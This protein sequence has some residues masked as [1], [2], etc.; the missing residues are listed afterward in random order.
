MKK[1]YVIV[2]SIITLSFFS[3]KIWMSNDN[4]FEE[5]EEEVKVANA[6]KVDVFVG[7]AQTQ[8]G[9]TTPNGVIK[10]TSSEPFKV[11]VPKEISYEIESQYGFKEWLAFSTSYFTTNDKSKNKDICFVDDESYKTVRRN[12]LNVNKETDTIDDSIVSFEKVYKTDDEGNTVLVP[13]KIIVTIKQKRDDICIV[14]IVAERPSLSRSTPSDRSEQVIKNMSVRINFSK[15]MDP[16][17]FNSANDEKTEES[18][19]DDETE[20]N[21]NISNNGYDRIIIKQGV[22]K[23]T[24]EGEPDDFDYEDITDHFDIEFS[25]SHKMITLKFKEDYIS[26]GYASQSSVIVTI[27]K[28]VR[29]A[30]GFKMANDSTISFNVGSKKDSLAPRITWLSAGT[31]KNFEAFQGVYRDVGSLE[32]LGQKTKIKLEGANLAPKDNIE[33]SFYTDYIKNRIGQD[34]KLILHVYA[35]DLAGAGSGQS[36]DGVESDVKQIGIRAK[37]LYNA[38]GTPDTE[39]KV[40][41]T[42]FELYVPQQN[43]T[44]L[45]GSFRDLVKNAYS[46]ASLSTVEYF[47]ALFEYDLSEMPDGLIQVDVA[48]Q[49]QVNNF[50]FTQEAEIYSSEYGNAYATLFIVKDTTPPDAD[51]NKGY[52]Q[53]DLHI[54]PNGRGMFNEEYYKRLSVI[55]SVAGIIKDKGNPRLVAPNSEL[56]WIVNPGSDTG[57][58]SSIS[59]EDSRWKLVSS[60]YTPAE[61]ALPTSDGP[62]DF[63]YA[64]M[65][66]LGNI[67]KAVL[68]KS[69]TY[70]NTNPTIGKITIE[71]VDD[72]ISTSITGNVLEHQIISIPVSDETAGLESI[73]ISTACMKNGNTAQEYELPFVSDK[74]V[75]KVIRDG[76]EKVI[77]YEIDAKNKKK[78]TFKEE[79]IGD[80]V[81]TI[82]GLQ[83]ADKDNVVDDS[84]YRISIKVTDAAL[85]ESEPGT[86]DIKND[87][88][89]P[90]IN[91]VAVRNINGGIVGNSAE[92]YWTTETEPQTVLYINLTETNTGAKVFDFADSSIKLTSNSEL[93]WDGNALPIEIDTSANK[94]TITDNEET[95]ITLAAG[96]EVII[97]NV[98]LVEE[99][100]IKLVISDLVTNASDEKTN[101]T[102]NGNTT[103]DMFKYD[104][105]TPEVKSVVLKDQAPGTGGAAETGYTDNEYIEATVNV[106]ASASGVYQITITGANFDSTTLVNGKQST[107][108]TEGFRVSSDGRTI[109]LK[110]SANTVNRILKGTFDIKLGNV[111]LPAGD[112]DKTVSFTVT[113]LAER[114]SSSSQ[115]EIRLDKTAPSWNGDGIFVA[116]SNASVDGTL[117]PTIYPHSSTSTSGNIK[118]GGNVYFYTN[119]TI[120]IS[121]DITDTNRKDNNKDLF[122]DDATSPVIEYTSVGPGTHLVYAVDKAGNKSEVRT[123]YV[124]ADISGPD[125]FDGY[126]TFA[127]PEVGGD[128]YRGNADTE[129]TKNYILKKNANPYTINVK[130]AGVTA[131]D[132]DVHGTN[133]TALSRY[134][135]LDPLDSASPIEYYAFSTDGSQNWRRITSDGQITINLPHTSGGCTPYTVYLKDGC[136]NIKS[137]TV[138]VNWYVDGS[139]TLG[140]KDLSNSLYV[141]TAKGITYYKGNTTPVLSLTKFS[142]TCYYPN[143][144]DVAAG[145]NQSTTKYTLKSR[146]LVWTNES[147]SPSKSDFYSTSIAENRFSPW[148]Y[149]TLKEANTTF[150]MT[151]NYPSYDNDTH[152]TSAY[153][154]YY[155]V[156]DKLGNYTIEQLNNDVNGNNTELWMYDNTPPRIAVQSAG[157]VNMIDD[158]NFYSSVSTLSL[159]IEDEQSGIKW[160]GSTEYSGNNVLNSLTAI[161]YSL[162]NIDPT[163]SFALTING[164]KDYVDNI[165]PDTEGLSVYSRDEW[166]KQTP[167]S[168]ATSG[169]VSIIRWDGTANGTQNYT[170]ELTSETDG[171]KKISVK[172]PRSVTELTFGLKVNSSDAYDMLGWIIKTEPISESDFEDFYDKS[173]IGEEGDITVLTRNSNNEYEYTYSK[174]DTSEKWEEIDNK[175]QYFY[176]INRAGLISHTPI[177]VDFVENPVPVVSNLE[178]TDVKTLENV[179]YIKQSSTISFVTRKDIPDNDVT[180]NATVAITKCEFFIGNTSVLTKDFTSSPVTEYTL[181][182]AET[183]VLPALY[184]DELTVKLYTETEESERYELT[185]VEQGLASSNIWMYDAI[186]PVINKVFVSGIREAKELTSNA[187]VAEYWTIEEEPQTSLR[188]NLTE[189]NT[190]AKIFDFANSSIKLRSDTVL[191]WHNAN[192]PSDAINIDLEANKLTITDDTRTIK[193]LDSG[194]DVIISNFDLV[195]NP[196]GNTVSLVISDYVINPSTS[197]TNFTINNNITEQSISLFKYDGASPTVNSVSLVDQADGTGGPAEA[198]FTDNV[199]VRAT[200]NVT[201]TASGVYQITVNGAEFDDTTTVN[202]K[203]ADDSTQGFVISA[204]KKTITLKTDSNGVNRIIRGTFNITIANVKLPSN[205]GDK[206]VTFTVTS[207]G[208]RTSSITDSASDTIRLDTVAPVWLGDGVFVA[209]SNADTTI[210]YPHA[211]TS[212]SGNIKLDSNG[213]RSDNGNVYFYTKDTINIAAAISD[214]NRK[215]E[216]ED[217]F[218]DTSTE[219]VAEYTSVL[220]G[221]HTVYSVDKAGNKSAVKTFYV[222]GDTA[223]TQ[224]FGGYVTF[225][226]PTGGNIYRGNA[227]TN[228]TKNYVIKQNAE[229]YRIILK[230]AGVTASDNDVHGAARSPLGRFAELDPLT[231]KSPVEY[232]KITGD[233][234]T[235]D[236]NVN[237]DWIV[238]PQ[239]GTIT[240]NL[241]KT[242]DCSAI[243]ISLKDGCSNVTTY[244]VPVNW[245]VDGS[246]TLGGKTLGSTLYPNSAKNITYYKGDTTP[247]LSLTNFNDSCYYPNDDDVTAGS[248]Q[249]N[250]NE[251]YTLKSRL[252]VWTN[253]ATEPAYT[254]FYSTTIAENRFSPWSYLT[255]KAA[256]TTFAMTHNYPSYD[257]DTHTTSAYKL[258][259]I[260]EDKLGNYTITQLINDTDPDNPLSLWM[261][262]NTTPSITVG[263]TSEKIN[264]IDGTN[265]YSAGSTLTLNLTDTQSG[266]E[267][268]GTVHYTG[269]GVLNEKSV[270]YP[271]SAVVPDSDKHLKINGL[272]DFVENVMPDSVALAYNSASDWIKQTTPTLPASNSISIIEWDGTENGTSNYTSELVAQNDG[273]KK[274]T[275]KSP[276]SVTSLTFGLKVNQNKIT[277]SGETSDDT[278][279]L[280]WIITTTPLTSFEQFYPSSLVG[281]TITSL[282]RNSDDEYEYTYS[283]L[284][285]AQKWEEISNRTQYF[286]PVNRA[287]LVCHNPI[288]VYFAENPVPSI[289][290]KEY[291]DVTN[292]ENINYV[293]SSSTITFTTNKYSNDIDFVKITK[294]EFYIGE[295][296]TPVLT[297]TFATPVHEYE[298]TTQETAVLPALSNN[299]LTVKLY[300]ANEESE[301]YPLTDST[302]PNN[303][304]SSNMWMYDDVS[305]IIKKI[306]VKDIKEATTSDASAVEYWSTGT[307]KTDLYITLNEQ[308]SGIRVF[309]FNG[310]TI[311]LTSASELY[312]LSSMDDTT[313]TRVTNVTVDTTANTLTIGAYNQAIRDADGEDV[314]V[315]ITNVQLV[316]AS[317]ATASSRPD[318]KVNLKVTDIA[319]K[320][321]VASSSNPVHARFALDSTTVTIT[322][323]AVTSIAGFNYDSNTPVITSFALSDRSSVEDANGFAIPVDPEFTNERYVTANFTVN[324]GESGITRLTVTGA[325]FEDSTTV[326]INSNVSLNQ[327][328]GF[329]V[330]NEGHTITFKNNKVYKGSALS[331]TIQNLYLPDEDGLKTVTVKATNKGEKENTPV[332]DSITLDTVAPVWNTTGTGLYTIQ[333]SENIYPRSLNGTAKAYGFV[334]DESVNS[335][336]NVYFYTKADAA[337]QLHLYADVTEANL[338]ENHIF[339][340]TVPASIAENSDSET[341]YI[342]TTSATAT[343]HPFLGL[344]PTANCS[345][346]VYV[347]DK[348]GNKTVTDKSFNLV[349]DATAPDVD[350]ITDYITFTKAMDADGTPV[351][352]VLRSSATEYS[353]KQIVDED[354]EP[355]KIFI[356]LSSGVTTSDERID[357]TSYTENSEPFTELYR[358]AS[359]S[360][361]TY[362]DSTKAPIEYFAITEAETDSNGQI[363]YTPSL[364]NSNV[365]IKLL[366][367]DT[368][369]K[370]INNKLKV[371]GGGTITIKLPK[372]E[373]CKPV[374]IHFKD[375]CGNISSTNTGIKWNVDGNIGAGNYSIEFKDDEYSATYEDLDN[376]RAHVVI[377]HPYTE[378]SS[379]TVTDAGGMAINN[380][381]TYYNNT[382]TPKLKLNYQDGCFWPAGTS[383][384]STVYSLRGRLIAWTEDEAPTYSDFINETG[385][386]RKWATTWIP[387]ITY[388]ADDPVSIEFNLPNNTATALVND[389]DSQSAQP[390]QLWY[391]IEDAAANYKIM[392]VKNRTS[393]SSSDAVLWMFDNAVPTLN[394]DDDVSFSKVNKESDNYYYYSTRSRTTYTVRDARSGMENTGAAYTTTT[395]TPLVT[396]DSSVSLPITMTDGTFVRPSI[397]VHDYIGN[398]VTLYLTGDTTNWTWQ[399]VPALNDDPATITITAGQTNDSRFS[400]G[401]AS[402]STT[403]HKSYSVMSPRNISSITATLTVNQTKVN[404]SDNT[405]SVDS[406]ALLGWIRSDTAL[407]TSAFADFYDNTDNDNGINQTSGT[408][409]FEKDDT[410]TPWLEWFNTDGTSNETTKYKYFYAVN[411]AG[412]ICQQP[413]KITFTENPIPAMATKTYNAHVYKF[414][415][416]NK[417]FLN[418]NSTIAFTTNKYSNNTT[419]VLITKAEFYIGESNTPA[420]TKNFTNP[421][422]EYQL[423]TEETDVMPQLSNDTL[424]VKLYTE[425]EESDKYPLT[426]EGFADSNLWTYDDVAPVINYI[427]VHN[428]N[429]GIEGTNGEEYWSTEASAQTALDI[430]LTET[431]TGAKVF[432]FTGS[433]VKL[434]GDTKI[435]WDG[436]ELARTINIAANTLTVADTSAIVTGSTGG[437]VTI[438]NVDLT[439]ANT[440]NTISLTVSDLVTNTSSA[441]TSFTLEDSTTIDMFKYDNETPTVNSVTLVDQGDGTGGAAE[442][443]Y[444]DNEYVE[445]TIN[446]TATASGIN[447]ITVSGA[448]FDNTTTVDSLSADDLTAGFVLSGNNTIILK[449]NSNTDNR[450]LRGTSFNIVIH[451]VKLPSFE[452]GSKTVS[453]TVTSLGNRTSTATSSSIILDTTPPAWDDDGIYVATSNNES[454]AI[455]PH[456]ST[457]SSGNVKINGNVYFYTQGTINIAAAISDTNRKNNNVDLFI[458]SSTNPVSEYTDV[459]SGTHTVYAVDRAGNKSEEKT[460][461]VV[462]DTSDPADFG[463]YVTFTM[464]TGGNIYTGN[465]STGSGSSETQNYVIKANANAYQIVMKLGGVSTSDK[466]VD[467]TSHTT[468]VSKYAQLDPLTTASPIEYYSTNG[469]TDWNEIGNGTITINLPNTDNSTATPYTI[470]L[471]DGCGNV[472][473]YTVPVNWTVDGSVTLTGTGKDLSHASLYVNAAKGITYYKGDTTPVISLTGFNDSCYYPNATSSTSSSTA[474]ENYTLKSRVL[475][476]TGATAP[477][478]S[479]FDGASSTSL[480]DWQYLTLMSG[481]DSVAMEHHY[482]NYVSNSAYKLYYIVEDKLGNYTIEQITNNQGGRVGQSSGSYTTTTS[483]STSLWMYDNTAPSITVGT[484]SQKINTI[485][486]TNYYSANSTLT[487]NITETQSGIE[488]DGADYYTGDDVATANHSV[489][490]PLTNITPTSGHLIISGLKDY[491]E[492]TMPDSVAL[493]YNSASNWVKQSAPTLPDSGFAA[494]LSCTGM[495]NGI[496]SDVTSLTTL[497]TSASGKKITVKVPHSVTSLKFNLKVTTEDDIDLLGWIISSSALT[498]PAAFYTSNDVTALTK[499]ATNEYEYNYGKSDTEKDWYESP[500]N[501]K[502]FYAVNKAGLICQ[503]PIIVEFASNPVPAV[504][505]GTSISYTNIESAGGVNYLKSGETYSGSTDTIAQSVIS[506]TSSVGLQSVKLIGDGFTQVF[507]INGSTSISITPDT[508]WAGNLSEKPLTMLLYTA[509]EVSDSIALTYNGVNKWTYDATRPAFTIATVKDSDDSTSAVQNPADTGTYY[510]KSTTNNKAELTFTGDSDIV[511]YEYKLSGAETWS[512]LTSPYRLP[513]ETSEAKTYN[514]RAIDKAGNP[515]TATSITVQKDVTGPSGS[516]A[517]TYTHS[518]ETDNTKID[519][520]TTDNSTYVYFNPSYATAVTL[521]ASS[522]TDTGAGVPTNYLCYRTKMDSAAG[523]GD[524]TAVTGNSF[525][526][527]L[528]AD[529][530]YYCEVIAKDKLGNAT[531]LHSYTFNGITPN[532][533]AAPTLKYGSSDADTSKY[534]VSSSGI[535]YTIYYNAGS[536]NKL[537]ATI[538]GTAGN[539]VDYFY[540]T[541]SETSPVAISGTSKT[542]DL[543]TS[544]DNLTETY[545]ITAKDKVGY[546]ITVATFAVNGNVPTGTIDHTNTN[547]TNKVG[548]TIYFNQKEST[549]KLSKSD[550]QGANSG[551]TISLYRQT[552]DDATTRDKFNAYDESAANNNMDATG[553]LI[554]PCP[555]SSP[556]TATYKIIAVDGVL[557]ESV[558]ATYILNGNLPSGDIGHTDTDTAKHTENTIYFKQGEGSVKLS[559]S[560]IQGAYDGDTIKLYRQTGDNAN[561]RDEFNAYD[562]SAQN[563]N[564]DAEGNLIIPCPTSSPWTATYKI[565]AVDGVLNE[566]V[567][568]TYTLN[569]TLPGGTV[570]YTNGDNTFLIAGT[571]TEADTIYY[572]S[573]TV[574][575]NLSFTVS[576]T[577]ASSSNAVSFFYTENEGTTANGTTITGS[578]TIPVSSSSGKTF[579]VWVKDR[580]G[581]TKLLKSYIFRTVNYELKL[582]GS[583]PSDY[584]YS[585][586]NETSAAP[587]IYYNK[588]RA[589]QLVL[590]ASGSAGASLPALYTREVISG[591]S[592]TYGNP[593]GIESATIS[594]VD[595][596]NA[597][598][599][600]KYQIVAKDSSDNYHVLKTLEIDGR[601]PSGKVLY[602]SDANDED[603]TECVKP[604]ANEEKYTVYFNQALLLSEDASIKL[605]TDNISGAK[606]NDTIT[607]YCQTGNNTTSRLEFTT[608]NN[609]V[610]GDNLKLTCPGT[611]LSYTNT[612]APYKIVAI[613]SI[614]N[615]TIL[616]EYILDGTKPYAVVSYILTGDDGTTAVNS[617]NYYISGNNINYNATQV[618]KLVV[619][620]SDVEGSGTVTLTSKKG[621]NDAEAISNNTCTFTLPTTAGASATYKIIA[622]DCVGNE[623]VLKEFTVTVNALIGSVSFDSANNDSQ[624]VQYNGNKVPK[625]IY[626]KHGAVNNIKLAKTGDAKVYYQIGD[627]TEVE[628]TDNLQLPCPTSDNYTVTYKILAG[629]AKTLVE[630]FKLKGYSP[631]GDI[632]IATGAIGKQTGSGNSANWTSATAVGTEAGGY[633]LTTDTSTTPATVTIKYNPATVNM[634]KLSPNVTDCGAGSKIVVRENGSN[635]S[636]LDYTSE[637]EVLVTLGAN[638]TGND[639]QKTYEVYAV[640]NVG[641][642]TKLKTYKFRAY[643]TAP[644][645]PTKTAGYNNLDSKDIKWNGVKVAALAEH[646]KASGTISVVTGTPNYPS[647][648]E[649]KITADVTIKVKINN[650]NSLPSDKIAY[651]ITNTYDAAGD[652]WTSWNDIGNT[653]VGNTDWYDYKSITDGYITIK[654]TPENIPNHE[655]Y[656]FV[657]L[658]DVFGNTNVYNIYNPDNTSV[659]WWYGEKTSNGNHSINSLNIPLT[660]TTRNTNSYS[661]IRIGQIPQSYS[662]STFTDNLVD[663]IDD[664]KS[665]TK[666]KKTRKGRKAAQIT[667]LTQKSAVVEKS[668]ETL[669]DTV[670]DLVVE[671]AADAVKEPA[672]PTSPVTSDTLVESL[673]NTVEEVIDSA[674]ASDNEVIV[675]EAPLGQAQFYENEEVGLDMRSV[676]VALAVLF[677][678]ISA[679]VGFIISRKKNSN[680][681][682]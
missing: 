114:T 466:K 104:Y 680:I 133:R 538:T 630:E 483:S 125:N 467:G 188:I 452:D 514:I 70:D 447:K 401:D 132:K 498:N 290:A 526:I 607:L 23:Y 238:M 479:N 459:A 583:A 224:A 345:F 293:K 281:T 393:S 344:T 218:I 41:N 485:S 569:G 616:A 592:E 533:S 252:L 21:T 217:L 321:S 366:D 508:T 343:R 43:N 436:N 198:G 26:E 539:G 543:P 608:T 437:R 196:Q 609:N 192:L 328:N 143:D 239:N 588:A 260:V 667:D 642:E 176:P 116:A 170:S 423:T 216:N 100:R 388:I 124:I 348:A 93:F 17:S 473:S 3:C 62:V 587:T 263:S 413:I 35:E 99:N 635:V 181:T 209:S 297:K 595:S 179:N 641:N 272:K 573:G 577:D 323:P 384:S 628:I 418:E 643:T 187:A 266:I 234:V 227:D 528:E 468:A 342:G 92:E 551:D 248:S 545:T 208:G 448:S 481:A 312:T 425:T 363:S 668:V 214:T 221:T 235:D 362:Y 487:L 458:D 417:N 337:S 450:L 300:T 122:I 445:A 382:G 249:V 77:D 365:W 443:G 286:Y 71:G 37:H 271:L 90:V 20:E 332:S 512:I 421:V 594:L 59:S 520:T 580:V 201:A 203:P 66:N 205:D 518:G 46:E 269:N 681:K 567:L 549:I 215:N 604:N 599:H 182:A 542:F 377:H 162:A 88:T 273:S 247:V 560:N 669:T 461:Y 420:L 285:T 199:Y 197:K 424:T 513:V 54:V 586:V 557:N 490:Y 486:G 546:E 236:E 48:A 435:I 375:A 517:P 55:E 374:V 360:I 591:T 284:N 579:K 629:D 228:S 195:E 666:A 339:F 315:K 525:N 540:Y 61:S 632:S 330:S 120:N 472:G 465:A 173:R 376:T 302:A 395:S 432:N 496:T 521:T 670:A 191:T 534:N 278:D 576:G 74:L 113:S 631:T 618:K 656:I 207:L 6:Q 111:K 275:V 383:E 602:D 623:N 600:K 613:D 163:S 566:K 349:K 5:I 4:I 50:G 193:T 253:I 536:V 36:L 640:D 651:A 402:G 578:L 482:P 34:S 444:T 94:L 469:G 457:A 2:L 572:N 79:L 51:A 648:Q 109:T 620:V 189:T 259:Y 638:W 355:Y 325:T 492:N 400:R 372:T 299:T 200:V 91:Y 455:Y 601:A 406:N 611:S 575:G 86:V 127:M 183:S 106:A 256:N 338:P 291:E 625:E 318:N 289:S 167:P 15:P 553:N 614:G 152:T 145:I 206:T 184:N 409:I 172:S 102:I 568:A 166:R 95:V 319:M 258:Y 138:P 241:P 257:N 530:I 664:I 137:A 672:I 561:T 621:D 58:V 347:I 288:I 673:V 147:T 186:A 294:C 164:L 31:G 27:K 331:V 244:T 210:I 49:D 112:G 590:N 606:A 65:D 615:E 378:N 219:P 674:N 131:A 507:T 657:W 211:S 28:D 650:A 563:N 19:N 83:I 142:D 56:K 47:G 64:L 555:T 396:I 405:S 547:H 404:P 574:T 240:V 361:N 660:G 582:N 434:N 313:G 194:E 279:L 390:Y 243:T 303:L 155:I 584:G 407:A 499:H 476:W 10:K 38:D 678:A 57:W 121:A 427:E 463:N 296:N 251:K 232:Y 428:I 585:V 679:L 624:K 255:L 399:N 527:S 454:P 301:K 403:T 645:S 682:K 174:T 68:F 327:T 426:K 254:D 213:N 72:Y 320:D 364:S 659:G 410:T 24:S 523:W 44:S 665:V 33:D 160:D 316:S 411:K 261:Y 622:T 165:M 357:G 491:V 367:M 148:S 639:G 652:A 451:N 69:V 562:G 346:E 225:T 97:T 596:E 306:F 309:D 7:F 84:T 644:T 222:V 169:A 497:S 334:P 522:V 22:E 314:L 354:I 502:Y 230:L 493:T 67:S 610:D 446:V 471:K 262:D 107:D 75:V 11:G 647:Y 510:V 474:T 352:Q 356:K 135:E 389:T 45:G 9:Q 231:N 556:W 552:G 280:G 141:N 387:K 358:S 96:G 140:E 101:F 220:P 246:V 353:I 634:V 168:P 646:S 158:I 202:G 123:F 277:P 488:W 52:V 89:P 392:Q 292:F 185:D 535:N 649:N 229:S 177:I 554:I 60:G 516:V 442:T 333:T 149:L 478:R 117:K 470:S 603:K 265:Y 433:S 326:I 440:G 29:D 233:S 439:T 489:A 456:T 544:G 351:G 310:S 53:P 529:H 1:L 139:V 153:K 212:E 484:T 341:T 270:A 154:L 14:P 633:I 8:Q 18:T 495:P 305:P 537:T 675:A 115:A 504:K 369:E 311:T 605:K 626:F 105:D 661:P 550:I 204:D 381:V 42:Q 430:N 151:H 612:A 597:A 276:R 477:E 81:V 16:K 548:N 464:P 422:N 394:R 431:N 156:E 307:D 385:S 78:L 571:G 559:K 677:V 663:T 460:F 287:G 419:D 103:I 85:N 134:P 506:F 505:S 676:Y 308:N 416:I 397:T 480:T 12:A 519:S 415:D 438:Q 636:T 144:D 500:N 80:C 283:K 453:F 531:T 324:T 379:G 475:A 350:T 130:L 317:S 13:E 340:K 359:N 503:T 146:L 570:S 511:K 150:A 619:T 653:S 108:A 509:N 25:S 322:D 63:T 617:S 264:T 449:T 598:I 190:G 87:S 441:V 304:A 335:E 98:D 627:A 119:T 429:S 386:Q 589:N 370:T 136:G 118:L 637:V 128:I 671:P 532:A 654:V 171:S 524:E 371:T 398:E 462:V 223:G 295:S 412:L 414:D 175:T 159:N 329:D 267:W 180:Q 157:K 242:R 76:E 494:L 501:T 515:S 73:E 226:M 298:L 408:Y 30:Y 581:N 245:H 564:M 110:T 662:S 82:Q 268:D 129:E 161:T 655:S 178:Y 126:I 237:T 593:A 565:I 658:K 250:P 373:T 274:I 32:N 336:H 282:T 40:S 541:N 380:G 39:A 368:S 558:L 391:V